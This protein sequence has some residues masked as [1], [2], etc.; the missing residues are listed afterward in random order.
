MGVSGPVY[1]PEDG[2]EI[3]FT[4]TSPIGVRNGIYAVDVTTD[5]VRPIVMPS[6]SV[7][8]GWVRISP[9]GS[10]IAYVASTADPARN[11]YQVH[12]ASAD[13]ATDVTLPMPEGA[14]FQDAPEWSND[15]TRLVLV[16]GYA[17]WNQDMV[18]AVVPADGSSVGVETKKGLT[19][20]C[21]TTNEWAP[22]D[23]SILTT[24][25]D[26]DGTF[27]LQMLWDPTTGVTRQAPWLATSKPAWQRRA[28]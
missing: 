4:A 12:V 26:L 23:S 24:P 7:G 18:L 13:G 11:T 15:G 8:R 10:R 1:R 27:V 28:P 6:A 20:C 25:T 2:H 14:T 17:A 21:D 16:R 3:V 19:G 22:D 9:D 5:M